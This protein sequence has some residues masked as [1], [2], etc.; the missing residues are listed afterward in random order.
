MLNNLFNDRR[1]EVGP[2]YGSANNVA[3]L[4]ASADGSGKPVNVTAMN[5]SV[6]DPN[7]PVQLMHSLGCFLAGRFWDFSASA[8]TRNSNANIGPLIRSKRGIHMRGE[9]IR[10]FRTWPTK[11]TSS[12]RTIPFSRTVL[13]CVFRSNRV[14]VVLLPIISPNCRLARCASAAA[15]AP[16]P[17]RHISRIWVTPTRFFP[18]I[19]RSASIWSK[20]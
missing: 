14:S 20:N 6:I 5:F 3:K 18:Q 10:P 16:K 12:L 7:D 17:K 2:A 11:P 4:V 19:S 9:I 8:N 13:E 1:K 15:L